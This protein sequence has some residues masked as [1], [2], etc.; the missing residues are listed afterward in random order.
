MEAKVVS[1][2]EL[3]GHGYD[4]FWKSKHPYLVVKGSRG[5]KKSKTTALRIIYNLMKYPDFNALVVRNTFTTLKDSC[6][7]ELKWA[8]NRF[9]VYDLFQFTVNPL[10]ITYKPTNQKIL[11][12]GFDDPLKLTS[13]TVP[14]GVLCCVWLEEAYELQSEDDFNKLEMSIRGEMP[15]G[16]GL[17]KQFIFTFNP[18]SANHWLK[19]RFFDEP[20]PDVLAMTTTYRCN[21]WLDEADIKKFEKMKVK[22]PRRYAIEANGEWGI[23]EG[24]IY[25]N[26]S[27]ERFDV[28]F[29][30]HQKGMKAAFGLDFGF[31]DPT[32]FVCMLVDMENSK[33]YVFDEL[34]ETGLTNVQL[35][36]KIQDMGYA[37]QKIVA[38]SAEPKAIAE[39]NS[40]GLKVSPARKGRD[41]VLHGIQL[42]QNFDWVIHPRCTNF[43]KEISNYCWAKD[44]Q[45]K[46]TDKPEHDFSHAMDASRYAL[47]KLLL[48]SAYSFN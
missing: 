39:L 22:N 14:K 4:D 41:S 43:Q 44:K 38:D 48:G 37:S 20:D 47:G 42:L 25:N 23:S 34:Y 32:A 21:E 8:A 46:P 5:S 29:L 3:V 18:W 15:P 27:I 45:G 19:A 28:D 10:E 7:A 26:F 6:F 24:L 1:L 30:R 40:L 12:R 2:R 35:A 16:S 31:T 17:W 36:H 33:I 11:F 13:V 9:G